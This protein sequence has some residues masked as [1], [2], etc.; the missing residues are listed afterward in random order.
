[1]GHKQAKKAK[2]KRTT[3]AEVLE[4]AGTSIRPLDGLISFSFKYL[5]APSKFT[6]KDQD[7]AYY[8][9]VIDRLTGLSSLRQSDL[10][11]DR[12][13]S[14]RAHPINWSES[15]VTENGFGI[16]NGDE[17]DESAYQ[18]TISEHEHGRVHGF[19]IDTVFY[20]VWLDP[21]HALYRKVRPDGSAK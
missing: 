16:P 18:F 14:L 2:Q 5:S 12:S 1:V 20:V 13:N 10:F 21:E 4:E 7:T 9:H 6:W 17:Y 19:V 11:S 3:F 8:T 15:R